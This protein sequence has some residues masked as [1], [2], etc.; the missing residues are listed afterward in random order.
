MN[1]TA[2]TT[3]PTVY[4]PAEPSPS[5]PKLEEA[6]L[7]WWEKERILQRSVE[8]HGNKTAEFVFY[9][10]PPFPNG[11]PHYGPIVPGFVKDLVPRYQTMRGKRV[12]RRFGWDCHG[13]PAELL[14]ETELK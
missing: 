9:D 8:R 5:F 1:D 3:K 6:V 10:G 12:D 7:A 13:L 14:S 11:L 2:A 4:P